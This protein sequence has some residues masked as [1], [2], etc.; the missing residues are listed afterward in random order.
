MSERKVLNRELEIFTDGACSG[1]PG[2]AAVAVIIREGGKVIKEM[3]LGIGQSTNNVAEYTA[4]IYALQEA[5]ILKA[6][7][8]S[9]F[10]DSELVYKQFTGTYDVKDVK[11]KVL[12][13]QVQHL[14]NGFKVFEIKHIPREQNKD[15][16]RLAKKAILASKKSMGGSQFASVCRNILC[17]VKKCREIFIV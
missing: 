10:T 11:M 17:C 16:D 13:D 2:Y 6:D 1:N 4:I 8:V 3:A 7:K 15:A 14:K 5:L 12:F 9:L